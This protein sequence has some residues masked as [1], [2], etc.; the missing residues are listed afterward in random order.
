MSAQKYQRVLFLDV[1]GVLNNG[2]ILD[3]ADD[4]DR[5][6]F[7]GQP[8]SLTSLRLLAR[9][10]QTFS[11]DIVLSSSWRYNWTQRLPHQIAL[12]KA[13]A[14]VGLAISDITPE[15]MD[16]RY[17]L[18]GREIRAWLEQHPETEVFVVLDDI[19]DMPDLV[20]H[21][22]LTDF[23]HGFTWR[24]VRRLKRILGKPGQAV[25]KTNDRS[26]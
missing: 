11:L 6:W 24:H 13:L 7:D 5:V 15:H 10:V 14:S 22:V 21:L 8:F 23:E 20:P 9:A 25:G 3:Q 18:R 17:G 26:K 1:D 4:R 19:N 2:R 12:E 16:M